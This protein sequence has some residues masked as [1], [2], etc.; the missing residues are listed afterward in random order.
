MRSRWREGAHCDGLHVGD[1]L[2]NTIL[3]TFPPSPPPRSV[4]FSLR[5]RPRVRS[6]V[7]RSLARSLGQSPCV[8]EWAAALVPTAYQSNFDENNFSITPL[9]CSPRVLSARSVSRRAG[10][11]GAWDNADHGRDSPGSTRPRLRRGAGAVGSH[12]GPTKKR[13][14]H[15]NKVILHPSCPLLPLGL[16]PD[17]YFRLQ[18]RKKGMNFF[19]GLTDRDRLRRLSLRSIAPEICPG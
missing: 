2:A 8:G 7:C 11:E 10:E 18:H 5:P 9:G 4:A 1:L 19:D 3:E 12:C 13:P 14:I 15:F 6:C 17:S 16:G